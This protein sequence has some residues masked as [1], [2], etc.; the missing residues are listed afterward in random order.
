MESLRK[1]LPYLKCTLDNTDVKDIEAL[2]IVDEEGVYSNYL[3]AN[4]EMDPLFVSRENNEVNFI[5]NREMLDIFNDAN[6]NYVGAKMAAYIKIKEKVKVM[7][8]NN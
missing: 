4:S 6:V 3:K 7:Y 5:M 1:L 8:E 2:F